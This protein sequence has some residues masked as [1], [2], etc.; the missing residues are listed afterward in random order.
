[1][2]T[3]KLIHIAAAVLSGTGFVLRGVLHLRDSPLLSTRLVRVA[4][5]VNDTVLLAAAIALT[6]QIHQYPFVHGWL[7]AKVIALLA[8]IALGLVAFR[9]GR[10][11]FI[12][13]TAFGGA[14]LAFVYIVAV[15]FTRSPLLGLLSD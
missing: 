5:H 1:M 9:Y 7:T 14:V 6:L 11:R 3:L 8:Y 12:R 10:T 15:A 4:P 13:S 2:T